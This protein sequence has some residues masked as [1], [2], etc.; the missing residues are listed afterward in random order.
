M[1]RTSSP[2]GKEGVSPKK[3]DDTDHSEKVFEKLRLARGNLFRGVS[4][5]HFELSELIFS[6]YSLLLLGLGG[7]FE[8]ETAPI[9]KTNFSL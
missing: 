5:P 9:S 2:Q 7:S 1:A 3:T 4:S 8:G 6:D